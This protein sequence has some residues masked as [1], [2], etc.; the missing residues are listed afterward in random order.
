[1]SLTEGLQQSTEEQS[2]VPQ[3]DA[4]EVSQGN[5]AESLPESVRDWDE[6]KNSD[7]P[8]KFFDQVANM[9]SMI[10]K[11]IRIP[12]ED[13][14]EEA[15]QD[16]IQKL[17]QVDG[18]MMK[19]E[20]A[21]GWQE[22]VAGL[23]EDVQKTLLD[24]LSKK[25]ELTAEERAAEM[26]AHEQHVKEGIQKLKDDWGNAFDKNI[27]LAKKAVQMLDERMGNNRLVK[28]L[29]ET[30][31]GDNPDIVAFF[32]E[33][34]TMM[35]EKPVLDGVTVNQF[36]VDPATA[37]ERIADIEANP[38]FTKH[39]DMSKERQLLIEKRQKYYDILYPDTE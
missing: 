12:S 13:A 26:N 16:F 1:M 5:W 25:D 8:E 35:G 2:N 27:T 21:D 10:G 28:A 19:P 14:G 34:A 33:V 11:S 30:G 15:M 24:N 32:T 36:A 9:R 18:V 6:V 3:G 22:M 31:A 39:G 4:Q 38:L 37:R 29:D 23:D 17:Q 7:S 20:N